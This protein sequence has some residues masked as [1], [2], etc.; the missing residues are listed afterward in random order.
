MSVCS[1]IWDI[2]EFI[3]RCKHDFYR[4][5]HWSWFFLFLMFYCLCLASPLVPSIIWLILY[6]D[7]RVSLLLIIVLYSLCAPGHWD[8]LL[9][10][11]QVGHY[12]LCSQL[13]SL[14]CWNLPCRDWYHLL[15]VNMRPLR[16]WSS[17]YFYTVYYI[18]SALMT[19]IV[20]PSVLM[21]LWV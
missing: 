14:F 3:A 17:K 9:I 6:L 8:S 1:F 15:K 16:S 12:C 21:K 10:A 5:L 4:F 18:I 13:C 2:T 20:L 7:W 11:F 19:K